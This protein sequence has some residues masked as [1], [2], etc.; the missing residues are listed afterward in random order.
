MFAEVDIAGMCD[1][2]SDG[3]V[4]LLQKTVASSLRHECVAF[5]AS[6]ERSSSST[7][8]WKG[9]RVGD[10]ADKA[11]ERIPRASNTPPAIPKRDSQSE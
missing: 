3:P 6:A 10:G 1:G 4:Q 2:A 5:I 11:W 9:N 7:T 8:A